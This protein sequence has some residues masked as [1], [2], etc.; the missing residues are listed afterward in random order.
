MSEHFIYKFSYQEPLI[1]IHPISKFT[2]NS[3]IMAIRVYDS[4]ITTYTMIS[5]I[6][7][8]AICLTNPT[9]VAADAPGLINV[10]NFG[11][12]ADGKTDSARAFQAAWNSACSSANPATIYV[13]AGRFFLSSANFQGQS[14]NNT[15]IEFC[16]DGTLVAPSD[17]RKFKTA[18]NVWIKFDKVVGVSISGGILDGQGAALWACK[19]SSG[20][21]PTGA[22]TLGF[23]NS[24]NIVIG[25]LS[26]INSQKFHIVFDGSENVNLQGITISA[27]GNS[28]NT[29]GVHIQSSSNVTVLNSRIATGDDCI[30]IGPGSSNLWIQGIICGP[31]HGISI[32]SLGW[33]AQEPGVQNVTVTTSMFKATENGVRIKTWARESN[34]FVTGVVFEHL[35]MVLVDNP[36]IIDQHYCPGSEIGRCPEAVSGIRIS[37]VTYDDIRG[38]SA[39]EVG[40][41]LD[42]S[43]EHPCSGITMEGVNLSYNNRPAQDICINAIG[44]SCS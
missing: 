14:C 39:K 6:I 21:C 43:K 19:A 33:T 35:T 24:R 1:S 28:P 38:T 20:S 41:K 10:L 4:K 34:G 7:L 18:D 36:V 12:M 29:D 11:A 31:G 8:S 3:L 5:A 17:Y 25:G 44:T 16:I 23:Y 22:T 42:C 26:S 32:G 9:M 30:S 40:V 15:A 2:F 37:N 27:A 13:P